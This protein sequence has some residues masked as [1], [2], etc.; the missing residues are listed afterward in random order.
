M[1]TAVFGWPPY[2]RADRLALLGKDPAILRIVHWRQDE[3]LATLA[4]AAS[5]VGVRLSKC[6]RRLPFTSYP[7]LNFRA[8]LIV[9]PT[10]G[11][12]YAQNDSFNP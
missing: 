2:A 10:P 12:N 4:K 1:F 8:A 7:V 3:M 5:G 6:S 11:M 9:I